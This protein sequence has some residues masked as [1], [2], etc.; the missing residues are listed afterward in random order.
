MQEVIVVD[1]DV[2]VDA[3][4]D[5]DLD[6]DVHAATLTGPATLSALFSTDII[7]PHISNPSSRGRLV[8]P[9]IYHFGLADAALIYV[10]IYGARFDDVPLFLLILQ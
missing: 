9:L 10:R 2:D 6:V 8:A 5:N 4:N 7:V 3:D 1:V